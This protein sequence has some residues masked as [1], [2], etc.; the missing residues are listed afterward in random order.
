MKD[1]KRE[2]FQTATYDRP[3]KNVL[4]IS[5]IDLRLTD[6]LLKFLN[7]ENLA[8][9][10]DHISLAGAALC[11]EGNKQPKDSPYK[12][13]KEFKPD[14]KDWK[15]F[16][17][18]H[19]ELAVMLHQVTDVYIVEH[20][21]CGAYENFLQQQ[22]N[23]SLKDNTECHHYFAETL[24]EQIKKQKYTFVSYGHVKNTPTAVHAKGTPKTGKN[25]RPVL[26]KQ[27]FLKVH[28]FIMDV[29]GD[30]FYLQQD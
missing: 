11:S 13:V 14:A 3:R 5:C 25:A 12:Y 16:I 18:R 2:P 17:L 23:V 8:N 20:D 19:V 27:D 21:D 9:R 30:V 24:S 29:K 4:V 1:V 28:K 6:N 15:K 7:A 22:P 10:Y 26:Y